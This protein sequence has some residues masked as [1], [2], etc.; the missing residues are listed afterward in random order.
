MPRHHHHH[1]HQASN[2]LT[3]MFLGAFIGSPLVF[4]FG[5][6]QYASA[7]TMAITAVAATGSALF[8]VGIGALI[9]YASIGAAYLCSAALESY[10]TDKGPLD[11]LKS[12]LNNQDGLSVKGVI[13]AI[14]AVLWSPFI[15]LG[16]LS[17]M[18]VKAIASTFTPSTSAPSPTTD[19]G[20]SEEQGGERRKK[21][22]PTVAADTQHKR[23]QSASYATLIPSL[24]VTDSQQ[25]NK[26]HKRSNSAPIIS[27]LYK[28]KEPSSDVPV[29]EVLKPS[30]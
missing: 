17:G 13:N 16:G 15:V 26:T 11:I 29:H 9:L 4:W 27:N 22:C 19:K 20:S 12:Q 21:C 1:N 23:S 30:C 8:S 6:F 25:H 5:F 24:G 14:G 3:L 18:A 10:K 2:G 7:P 28:N